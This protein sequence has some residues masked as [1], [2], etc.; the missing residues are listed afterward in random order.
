MQQLLGKDADRGPAPNVPRRSDPLEQLE[1]VLDGD[2]KTMD[3]RLL[4]GLPGETPPGSTPQEPR[5]RR[6]QPSGQQRNRAVPPVRTCGSDLQPA[7]PLQR[8]GQRM[9]EVEQRLAQRETA[10][11]TQSEQ[12][13]IVAELS[14]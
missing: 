8:I 6:L 2:D 10:E 4:D 9:R 12:R 13:Q 7:N 5:G 14:S 11:P 1:R 3:Q